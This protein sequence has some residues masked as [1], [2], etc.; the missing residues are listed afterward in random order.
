M[1]ESPPPLLEVSDAGDVAPVGAAAEA[2]PARPPAGDAGW[3]DFFAVDFVAWPLF[4]FGLAALSFFVDFFFDGPAPAEWEAGPAVGA[5]L[6][7][8]GL[9]EVDGVVVGAAPPPAPGEAP[10]VPPDDVP[11]EEPPPPVCRGARATAG[12]GSALRFAAISARPVTHTGV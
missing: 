9:G 1:P 6:E 5:A 7:V 3:L 4:D 8:A 11:P 10:P 2:E 12:T